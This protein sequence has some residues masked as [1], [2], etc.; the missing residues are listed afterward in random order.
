MT[1]RIGVL[2]SGGDAPGMNAAIVGVIER[3]DAHGAHTVAFRRGYLGL[4]LGDGHLVDPAEALE[5]RDESGTWLQSSR[6]PELQTDE[7]LRAVLMQI[8]AAELDGLVVVGGDGSLKGAQSL[9]RAGACVA[10][11]PATID[12]D[13]AGTETTIGHDSAVRYAVGV[14][15]QLR[16]T[17]YA[18]PGRA[19]V[20]QTLGGHGHQLAQAVGRVSAVPDV[21]TSADDDEIA[22][23]G[24][25]LL[26]RA[27][28]GQAIAVMPEGIGNAVDIAARLHNAT[29]IHVHPTILGHAQRAAPT[30]DVDIAL[31]VS[32]GHDAVDAV[33][34]RESAFI[35]LDA[36]GTSAR[37]QIDDIGTCTVPAH[38]GARS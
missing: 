25:S 1:P 33:L 15:H 27:R 6:Y 21:L 7:G 38:R 20:V 23:V 22:R 9:A 34:Q 14:I 17:G 13:I 8:E 24:A 4:S 28:H 37:Q 36:L 18:L 2:T 29:A 3:A 32:A 12:N 19:F 26:V 31:G 11:V 16:L 30:T 35:T 10:F 5:H